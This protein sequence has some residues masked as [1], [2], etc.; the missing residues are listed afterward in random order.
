MSLTKIDLDDK[1][2]EKIDLTNNISST[3]KK[4]NIKKFYNSLL[5]E[6][7]DKTNKQIINN[8][9]NMFEIF[10]IEKN[11]QMDDI[12]SETVLKHII[13]YDQE[14]KNI[15]HQEKIELAFQ[16]KCKE[17][18]LKK[19][20]SLSNDKVGDG[21]SGKVGD[22]PS[23]SV[24][25]TQT[26]LCGK[27]KDDNPSKVEDNISNNI[28]NKHLRKNIAKMTAI[29]EKIINKKLDTII[30]DDMLESAYKLFLSSKEI[31]IHDNNKC[32]SHNHKKSKLHIHI[33]EDNTYDI[34]C[35]PMKLLCIT[36][37]L[38]IVIFYDKSDNFIVNLFNELKCKKEYLLLK[39]TD[40]TRYFVN[41]DGEIEKICC[42]LVFKYF[43]YNSL[44][45]MVISVDNTENNLNYSYD[46]LTLLDT[47]R[48]CHMSFQNMFS[49]IKFY[50]SSKD[51]YEYDKNIFLNN[52]VEMEQFLL[53]I[54]IKNN[55]KDIHVLLNYFETS[56]KYYYELILL[57]LY[58]ENDD[59]GSMNKLLDYYSYNN[60]LLNMDKFNVLI[61]MY[62][63]KDCEYIE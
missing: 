13:K 5:T 27:V 33:Q 1:T 28:E 39:K 58:Y 41:D 20:P 57:Y 19:Y 8:A 37:S 32:N 48:I 60:D 12:T 35:D 4:E 43:K 40:D 10:Y 46:N 6:T 14:H 49:I 23:G 16:K 36:P 7:D 62:E 50:I 21:P 52:R 63:F 26:Q 3:S 51:E 55:L 45:G 59:F 34:V 53:S 18:V 47:P 17:L 31:K 15:T 11:G 25:G 24:Q 61:T 44:I 2:I 54:L 38:D 30:T 56:D 22:G 9:Y 42:K 29:I